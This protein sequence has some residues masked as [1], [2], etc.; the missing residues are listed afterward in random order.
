MNFWIE[1][2]NKQ[3]SW[4]ADFQNCMPVI[5]RFFGQKH[6]LSAR[7]LKCQ[8]ILN[9]IKNST[10][11]IKSIVVAPGSFLFKNA[12]FRWKLYVKNR[13]GDESMRNWL[14]L[15]NHFLT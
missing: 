8:A 12:Y 11:D 3:L 2:P 10:D 7:Y 14:L 13:F 4:Y 6:F 1:L 5:I 9:L 15:R